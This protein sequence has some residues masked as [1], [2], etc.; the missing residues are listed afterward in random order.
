VELIDVLVDGS[1][2]L[3][4]LCGGEANTSLGLLCDREEFPFELREE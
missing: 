2:S 1:T 4:V 3:V